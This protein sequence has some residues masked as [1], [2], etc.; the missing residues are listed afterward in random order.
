MAEGGLDAFLN[1]FVPLLVVAFF[2]F[3][4]YKPLKP[5]VDG[6]FA[7][8]GRKF[9]NMGEETNTTGYRSVIVYE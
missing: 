3:T 8:V 4:I 1:V 9:K 5:Q 7:W 2:A 6:L